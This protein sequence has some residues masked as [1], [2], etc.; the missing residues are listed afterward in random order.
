MNPLI[1]ARSLL[2]VPATRPERLGKALATA[3]GCVIVDL[4]D[5]VSIGEKSAARDRLADALS[6][7]D[8]SERPRV[9][10]RINAD[11]T[12]W[13]D[14]DVRMLAAAPAFGGVVLPKAE[15]QFVL[16]RVGSLLVGV[17]LVPLIESLAGLDNADALARSEGVAR[18]AF[19]H[20]DFQL[21]LGMRCEADETELNGVRFAIVAASR[22]ASLAAP[23]DGVTVELDDP[24]RLGSDSRRA[25][26]LGFGAKLCIHPK[27]VEIVNATFAPTQD[28]VAWARQ[29]L[30]LAASNGGQAFAFDGRMVDA[31]V[32]ARARK[33]LQAE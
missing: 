1:R 30:A 15:S 7:L 9:L 28:E 22:R 11:G 6:S 19:G 31:P 8:A 2:F 29:V 21:D 24:T 5:A 18:L 32:I 14:D 26:A 3:A 33:I 16:A 10:V 13:H 27:Q 20:L 4:E 12:A 23:I 17:A 25:L